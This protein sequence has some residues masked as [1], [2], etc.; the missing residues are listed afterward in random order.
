MPPPSTFIKL[1]S[2]TGQNSAKFWLQY[3]VTCGFHPEFYWIKQDSNYVL[4]SFRTNQEAE[5]VM[6]HFNKMPTTSS[7]TAEWY[8]ESVAGGQIHAPTFW[9]DLV[10]IWYHNPKTRPLFDS[11]T[12]NLPTYCNY[13]P[14][15]LRLHP[16]SELADM[17]SLMFD[18]LAAE[19]LV[20]ER[21]SVKIPELAFIEERRLSSRRR[22]RSRIMICRKIQRAQ[23]NSSTL[24]PNSS[25]QSEDMEDDMSAS[26]HP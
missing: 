12:G 13:A 4:Y 16:M 19:K 5:L 15:G 24:T 23:S 10:G 11:P 9:W 17:R 14:G 7:T 1:K 18:S 3:M 21:D 2:S 25:P 20:R 6:D 22:E 26:Q 8:Y